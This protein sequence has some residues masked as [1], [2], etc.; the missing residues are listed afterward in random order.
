MGAVTF[1]FRVEPTPPQRVFGGPVTVFSGASRPF[2][3][4]SQIASK[5]SVPAIWLLSDCSD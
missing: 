5:G 3:G 4:P 2:I 1:R